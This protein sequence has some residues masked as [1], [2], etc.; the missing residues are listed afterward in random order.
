[1]EEAEAQAVL[2]SP[3][4]GVLGAPL[5]CCADQLSEVYSDVASARMAHWRISVPVAS[6][7]T[8]STASISF[9][10]PVMR[11]SRDTRTALTGTAPDVVGR[12]VCGVALT[13]TLSTPG[14]AVVGS[15]PLKTVSGTPPSAGR[16]S[17]STIAPGL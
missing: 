14:Q 13:L 2:L 3:Q 16:A 1:V 12:A 10:E 5:A 9:Q 15:R 8:S 17:T 6:V 11:W 4:V 7:P